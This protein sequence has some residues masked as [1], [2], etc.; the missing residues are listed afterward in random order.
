VDEIEVAGDEAK[1]EADAEAAAAE[2]E[3]RQPSVL[4]RVQGELDDV[5]RALERLDDGSYGTCQACGA[6]I[7]D[8][9]L[10]E[11]PTARFCGEHE[12]ESHES[13]E[14]GVG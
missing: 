2:V 8:E 11:R 14:S 3:G 7:P 4:D 12:S 5:E 10:E 9:V 1:A 13:H 6:A